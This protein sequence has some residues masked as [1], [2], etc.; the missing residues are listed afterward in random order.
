MSHIPSPNDSNFCFQSILDQ[1]LQSYKN[2][3]GEDLPSHPL[4]RDL[5]AC[6]T[7]GAILAVLQSQLPGYDQPGSN[8][9]T[10]KWPWLDTTVDVLSQIL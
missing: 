5:T 10:S 9:D 7:T 4:F 6:H 8:K 2:T 3:T 1:A